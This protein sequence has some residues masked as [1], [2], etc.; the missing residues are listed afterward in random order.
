MANTLNVHE[1]IRTA[2]NAEIARLTDVD[3][4]YGDAL[5]DIV[6]LAQSVK[7]AETIKEY[8]DGFQQAYEAK[9]KSKSSAKSLKSKRKLIL[10]F[11]AGFKQQDNGKK[12]SKTVA[13][14]KVKEFAKETNHINGVAS[15][16]V[17]FL[18]TQEDVFDFKAEFIK[19]L[20]KT[21]KHDVT[22]KQ[23]DD[24]L[25]EYLAGQLSAE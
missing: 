15:Q 25:T 20:K 16:I 22:D 11:L 5:V 13:A 19:Y 6:N 21:T 14:E 23:I 1:I 12:V 10:D 7:T 2:I 9:G 17:A 18:K 24:M 8:C 4:I 3:A